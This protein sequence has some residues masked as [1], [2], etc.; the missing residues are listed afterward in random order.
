MSNNNKSIGTYYEALFIAEALKRELEV[1]DTVGDSLPYD[2]VIVDKGKSIRVQ[3]KGTNGY[4]NGKDKVYRFLSTRGPNKVRNIE[5]DVL[6]GYC[7]HKHG[8]SWYIIPLDAMA[9]KSVKV[10]PDSPTSRGMYEKYREA[11][12]FFPGVV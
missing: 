9:H 3:V 5:F 6:A 8:T 4:K 11:W 2:C 10:Y 1:C 7:A 12:S